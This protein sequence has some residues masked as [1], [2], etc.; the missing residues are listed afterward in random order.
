MLPTT[1]LGGGFK[2]F[3]YFHPEAWG[4]DP[5]WRFAYFSNG[6]V[7]NHQLEGYDSSYQFIRNITIFNRKYIFKGS[8]FQPAMLDYRSVP[9]CSLLAS[10][11]VVLEWAWKGAYLHILA[12]YDWSTTDGIN[13]SHL[14][15][16]AL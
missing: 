10:A 16:E 3:C 5:I 12:G 6:L 9:L 1:F 13:S 14:N 15:R 4:N 11:V 7:K 2:Y 8:I